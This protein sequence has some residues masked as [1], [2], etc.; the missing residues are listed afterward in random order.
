MF[1][2]EALTK[3][4][5][6]LTALFA[7]YKFFQRSFVEIRVFHCDP[8]VKFEFISGSLKIFA[9]FF[10]SF[11]CVAL[12]RLPNYALLFERICLS[13]PLSK[14]VLFIVALG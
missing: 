13:D 6:F 12:K 3:F 9:F 1:F 5:F 7:I 10:F 4:A 8:W 14:F 11:V 2:C